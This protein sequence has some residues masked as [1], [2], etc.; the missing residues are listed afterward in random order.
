VAA[1]RPFAPEDAESAVSLLAKLVPATVHTPESL[2]WRQGV[3]PQRGSWVAVEDYEVIGFATAFLLLWTGEQ[4]K[5]RVWAGVREDRRR[6]GIG[7]KLWERALRH[8]REARRHTTEVD[9]DA[10]GLEFVQHRGFTEYDS[11]VMSSL[12]LAG[13]AVESERRA[14][15]R[16][17][18]LGD[19]GARDEDLFEFYGAAGGI[20]P[21]APITSELFRTVILGNPT[22]DLSTSVV[23]LDDGGRIVSLSWLLVDRERARAENEWTAT[24]PELRGRGLAR[25]A[26]LESMRRAAESGIRELQTGNAPDNAP[27]RALNRSLGYRELYVRRDLELRNES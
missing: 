21:G 11:E 18:A 5:S 16:V 6:Q 14:G 24:L 10:A 4:G 9:G 3:E 17:V 1:I 15:F 26:K 19:L 25:L 23:V 20:P 7:S 27:M 22:L 2:G 8:M 13:W 12:D